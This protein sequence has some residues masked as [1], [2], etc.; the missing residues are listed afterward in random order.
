M[1]GVRRLVRDLRDEIVR[2]E[3][4][5]ARVAAAADGSAAATGEDADLERRHEHLPLH[6]ELSAL[7]PRLRDLQDP[8][9]RRKLRAA[10]ASAATLAR[11]GL[12]AAHQGNAP[13]DPLPPNALLGLAA[14][15][16]EP[17]HCLGAEPA[18]RPARSP[19]LCQ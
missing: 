4:D 13:E 9:V 7:A 5:A 19:G 2:A 14:L 15:L 17:R 8:A 12:A 6:P 1:R 11:E 10:I 3:K 16:L 18:R